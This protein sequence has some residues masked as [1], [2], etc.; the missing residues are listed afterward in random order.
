LQEYISGKEKRQPVHHANIFTVEDIAALY[1]IPAKTMTQTRDLLIFAIGICTL[2]RSA[3]LI[4]LNVEDI[5]LKSDGLIVSLH[6]KKSL[7]QSRHPANMG[8]WRFLRVE[9]VGKHE[10]VCCLHSLFR[11]ALEKNS[12][13]TQ[14][15]DGF[16]RVGANHD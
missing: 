10:K 8:V 12:A 9:S 5:Q 3:E 13:S 11:A 14:A 7:C 1:K 6:R 15:S 16:C 4:S 2:A